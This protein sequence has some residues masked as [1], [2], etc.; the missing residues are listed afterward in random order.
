MLSKKRVIMSTEQER[1]SMDAFNLSIQTPS[2][3]VWAELARSPFYAWFEREFDMP[4]EAT[5]S[6]DQVLEAVKKALSTPHRGDQALGILLHEYVQSHRIADD[7][8]WREMCYYWL[9]LTKT[10]GLWDGLWKRDPAVLEAYVENLKLL[11]ENW[12]QYLGGKRPTK[13]IP[14]DAAQKI[15][16]WKE[17]KKQ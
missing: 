12:A 15:E 2:P 13:L 17:S 10:L 4:F 6:S 11:E 3:P 14:L 7:P 8:D 9:Y 1:R 16:E 5:L